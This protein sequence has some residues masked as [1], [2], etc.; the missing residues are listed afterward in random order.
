MGRWGDR[1]M[2]RHGDTR[3]TRDNKSAKCKMKSEKWTD[4]GYDQGKIGDKQ[5]EK[6]KGKEE[7]RE[8]GEGGKVQSNLIPSFFTRRRKNG[9]I[10]Y[11][12]CQEKNIF[13]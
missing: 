10:L 13:L 3:E 2:G 7:E 4:E 9:D 8:K 6:A 11:S 1:E 5:K 12:P